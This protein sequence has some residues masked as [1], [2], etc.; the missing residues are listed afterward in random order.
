MLSRDTALPKSVAPPPSILLLGFMASLP[1]FGVDMALPALADT[2]A[3]LD[4]SAHGASLAI[5][6]YM[7]SFGMAPLVYGPIS[8]RFGR[9]PIILIGC[10]VFILASVGCALAPSLPILLGWRVIAGLGAATMALAMAMAR[11]VYDD[12]VFRQKLSTIVVAIYVSPI[13]APIAGAAVLALA[14]WRTIYVGLATLG[15]LLLV[16]VWFGL[17]EDSK[18]RRP[19]RL[20][21]LTMIKD[22]GRVLSHPACRSY[23]LASATSFGVVGAYATGSALFFIK[24]AGMSPNQ[25]SLIFG[26]TSLASAAGAVLDSRLAAQGIASLYTVGGGLAIVV[27]GST[28]LTAMTLVGWT[29]IAVTV[30]LFAAMTFSVGGAGP[31]IMQG[32]MQQLP[33]L[34]GTISAA[35][36]CL[37]MVM[38]SLSSG[39]AAIFF[40]GRTLLSTTVAML[41]CSTLALLSFLAAA[42]GTAK[43][44]AVPS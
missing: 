21:I 16:G 36:N 11:D 1:G 22:Y 18:S 44:C 26:L 27:L 24:A 15:L 5:S 34:S 32:S 39:L 14:G 23:L 37:A 13:A 42:R 12:S 10:L 7:A 29:P 35:G 8:D 30:L 20:R 25:F 19:G 41:L 9:K 38:G 33:E 40:D 3:S 4:A 31:G 17:H 43:P 6:T 2:A 28:I